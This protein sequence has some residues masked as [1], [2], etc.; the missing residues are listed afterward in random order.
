MQSRNFCRAA[1]LLLVSPIGAAAQTTGGMRVFVDVAALFN[2]DMTWGA[3]RVET[4]GISV[5]GGVHLT[6]HS[7]IRLLVDLPAATTV[8]SASSLLYDGIPPVATANVTATTQARNR[9]VS[10]AFAWLIPGGRRWEFMPSVGCSSS[11]RADAVTITTTP[12][13]SG[14]PAQVTRAPSSPEWTGLLVGAGAVVHLTSQLALVSEVRT[15]WYPTAENGS[16][17]VRG[18]VGARW[19]F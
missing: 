5:G 11:D 16:T 12:L 10:A 14:P 13:P 6:R 17:I 19:K 18:A 8:A 3:S 2:R 4:A 9:S 1:I 15:I 7:E